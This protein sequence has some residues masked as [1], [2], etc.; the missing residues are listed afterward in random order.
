MNVDFYNADADFLPLYKMRLL[1][2]RNFYKGT[3]NDSANVI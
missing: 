1:A 3:R 2:G